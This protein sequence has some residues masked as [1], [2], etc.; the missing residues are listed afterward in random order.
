MLSKTIKL[1]FIS[2]LAIAFLAGCA[3]TSNTE[4]PAAPA[5][6]TTTTAEPTPAPTTTVEPVAPALETVF[7][8]AFDKS[9]LTPETRALLTAHA[10]ALKASPRSIRL[11]GHADERGTREYNIALGE[12]RALSVRDYLRSEGVNSLIEVVSYG[13][14][15]PEVAASNESAWQQNRRVELK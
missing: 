5:P 11:E 15:R 9:E 3:S 2:L 6:T 1:G 13:E 10:A 14:E 12:R 7:Y 8:F 4:E